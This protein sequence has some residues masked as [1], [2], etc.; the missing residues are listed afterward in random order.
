MNL[1]YL[2]RLIQCQRDSKPSECRTR[3]HYRVHPWSIICLYC[4]LKLDTSV[5]LHTCAAAA[6]FSLLHQLSAGQA[7]TTHAWP[8][9]FHQHHFNQQSTINISHQGHES[10]KKTHNTNNN[11]YQDLYPTISTK[12]NTSGHNHN[13]MTN[14]GSSHMVNTT[15]SSYHHR[16][17]PVQSNCL[18]CSLSRVSWCFPTH[19]IHTRTLIHTIHRQKKKF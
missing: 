10:N 1:H 3:P 6:V 4:N 9:S 11:N 2:I 13:S 8:W 14:K 19:I 5:L 16:F 7:F 12:T 18:F 15:V 17:N